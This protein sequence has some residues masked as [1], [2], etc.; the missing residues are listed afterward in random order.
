MK[1]ND[2]AFVGG[3]VPADL[4][5]RLEDVAKSQGRSKAWILRGALEAYLRAA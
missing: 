2:V 1:R 5:Q 4:A 3:Q